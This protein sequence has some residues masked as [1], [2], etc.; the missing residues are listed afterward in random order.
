MGGT[1]NSEADHPEGC[2]CYCKE[3]EDLKK[4]IEELKTSLADTVNKLNLLEADASDGS[5]LKWL[6]KNWKHSVG[7]GALTGLGGCLLGYWGNSS[8]DVSETASWLPIAGAA[9]AGVTAGVGATKLC[10]SG[11]VSKDSS[12]EVA[13]PT[14]FGP[15]VTKK[16]EDLSAWE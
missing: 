5:I 13:V 10:C 12:K 4:E 6:R 7:L 3:V 8:D 15:V 14:S 1:N 11:A 2:I 16:K 9:L